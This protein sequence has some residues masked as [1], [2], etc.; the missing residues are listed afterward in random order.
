MTAASYK[1]SK[2]A[3]Q[4]LRSRYLVKDDTGKV[5]ETP[6]EMFRRVARHVATAERVFDPEADVSVIEEKFFESM[7]GLEFLPNSPTLMNAGTDVGQLAACFVLPL[8]DSLEDIFEAAKQ[9]AIIFKSGGGVGISFSHLRPRGDAVRSTGGVASGPVSFMHI[10]DTGAEVVKQGGRRRGAMMGALRVDHPDIL[11]FIACKREPGKLTSF[12]TSVAVTDAFMTALKEDGEY[13]FVDPRTGRPDGR[14]RATDIFGAIVR[15]A[16]ATGEP[17]LLFIDRMNATN[18]TPGQGEFETTNPCG[19]TQL[20]PYESCNLASI[21]LARMVAG[22]EVDEP[23]LSRTTQLAVH[24]LDNVV[25][26][27][28]HPLPEIAEV[29][30]ANR[31][32][33]LGVMGFAEMLIQLGVPYDSEEALALAGRVT[34]CIDRASREESERLAEVRGAFPNFE[35]SVLVGDGPG[36]RNATRL[37]V[38]PTGTISIIAGVTGGIEP[39]FSVGLHRRNILDGSEFFELHP[40]FEEFARRDGF[41]SK[42]LVRKVARAV[43]IAG[44]NEVPEDVRRLFRTAHD[45]APEWH[46]KMQ[47]A[48]QAHVDNSVSKTVNL[49]AVATEDDVRR[50]FLLAYELGCKGITVYRDGSRDMQPLSSGTAA[51]PEPRR[52]RPRP[53]VLPG[54]TRKLKTGCGNIFVTITTD[55]DGKP[56][57]LFAK[58]GKAGVCS[59]AQCEAIGRLASLALRSD[60]DPREIE[61]QLGGIT[62]HAPYGFGPDKVLSCA[63]A[64]ARAVRLELADEGPGARLPVRVGDARTQTGTGTTPPVLRTGACPECGAALVREGH[65]ASCRCCGYTQCA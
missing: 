17:G 1:P 57:E 15:C 46:V 18:P 65:C 64:I 9:A 31:K 6:E 36:L 33:G 61:K 30:K 5:V 14:K 39:V 12:N 62:C 29:T 60:V 49:P 51:K 4:V 56:L 3:E 25:E 50:V 63:D 11:E 8:G 22:G 53:E 48:F 20:L 28:R 47:G 38:A 45:V 58:H 34:R 32:I 43:S 16:H 23:R 26:L 37:A 27:N 21:N 24:F 55:E 19:E 10:F 40:L 35:Q 54:R 7:R 41:H 59:Q 42:G 44:M 2:T 13:E 52:P